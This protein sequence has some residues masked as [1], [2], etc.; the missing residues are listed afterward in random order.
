[1]LST[2]YPFQKRFFV[3][4]IQ[5]RVGRAN[6]FSATMGLCLQIIAQENI[7]AIIFADRLSYLPIVEIC[8]AR[9]D[10][11][12]DLLL[13]DELTIPDQLLDDYLLPIMQQGLQAF[14]QIY[15]L[16]SVVPLLTDIL[17]VGKETVTPSLPLSCPML[18]ISAPASKDSPLYVF[19]EPFSTE[20]AKRAA[21]CAVREFHSIISKIFLCTPDGNTNAA[22]LETGITGCVCPEQLPEHPFVLLSPELTSRRSNAL[23]W[24]LFALNR[25]WIPVI[26]QQS[27]NK[28]QQYTPIGFSLGQFYALQGI[29]VPLPVFTSVFHSSDRSTT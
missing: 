9:F 13:Y 5:I 24:L 26:R 15:S 6:L 1:M 2:T 8:R 27:L 28:L 10:L 18:P 3:D 14:R 7:D 16:P 22:F 23:D 12:C 25:G 11:P 29:H 19:T 4:P 21:A 17:G 20:L